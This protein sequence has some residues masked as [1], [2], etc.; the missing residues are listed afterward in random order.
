LL[1]LDLLIHLW[2]GGVITGEVKVAQGGT[3]LGH[4]LLELFLLLVPEAVLLLIVALVARVIMVI[5]VVVVLVGGVKFLPLGAVSD[6]VCGITALEA[7][8]RWPPPLLAE[9]V[10]GVELSCQQGNLI[11]RMLSYCL[12][13]VAARDNKANFKQDEMVL[14]GLASWP[15][16]RALVTKI[17]LEWEASWLGWPFLDS[18]WDY[19]LLNSFSV[20]SVAK[21]A[22]SSRA[23]IF[24][25]KHDH[26][27]HITT[28][29]H[30]H[31]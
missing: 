31:Y 28:V 3:H 9:L 29:Q 1:A 30:V 7:A 24:I 6:K 11:I 12:S 19:S 5:V 8:P 2:A 26:Q 18:S 23:V 27:V 14:V 16:T 10:Q 20:S 25:P 13:E 17:L 21:L 15:Q 22:Y 4:D